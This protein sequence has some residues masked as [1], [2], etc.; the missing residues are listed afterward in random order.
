MINAILNTG[1][2]KKNKNAE[3]WISHLRIKAN[4]GGYKEKNSKLKEQ[5]INGIRDDD[6]MTEQIYE[7][8]KI[9]KTNEIT[10]EQVVCW[11]G[12]AEA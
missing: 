12:R 9:K 8:I 6:M 7:P 10:S 5:F 11:A 1:K 3:E 4:K 2:R